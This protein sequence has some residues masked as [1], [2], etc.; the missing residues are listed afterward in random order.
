MIVGLTVVGLAAFASIIM[1]LMLTDG[2]KQNRLLYIL[3]KPLPQLKHNTVYG[4]VGLYHS[5]R[6]QIVLDVPGLK[7]YYGAAWLVEYIECLIHEFIHWSQPTVGTVEETVYDR[8]ISELE[9]Y[10]WSNLL[11]N[12]DLEWRAINSTRTMISHRLRHSSCAAYAC[13]TWRGGWMYDL[14][15]EENASDNT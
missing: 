2:L 3:L 9:A 6:N 13:E 10:T 14:R 7:S 12:S 15:E 4:A 8:Y 5:V 1:V 11:G